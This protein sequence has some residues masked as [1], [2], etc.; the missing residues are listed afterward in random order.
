MNGARRE[1]VVRHERK[2]PSE[3]YLFVVAILAVVIPVTVAVATEEAFLAFSA[4]GVM[5]LALFGSYCLAQ[6]RGGEY[7]QRF[8]W[9]HRMFDFLSEIYT[10]PC[11]SA[12]AR[13]FCWLRHGPLM[14]GVVIQRRPA[15]PVF[16]VCRYRFCPKC[17]IYFENGELAKLLG[18]E[19]EAV[20][21]ATA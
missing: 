21:H 6:S 14:R 3:W 2:E 15:G 19:M 10:R 12:L 5:A 18:H 11:M 13:L 9:E 8:I 17:G 7:F 16:L 1:L 4:L 20:I